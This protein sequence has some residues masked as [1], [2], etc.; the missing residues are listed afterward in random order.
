MLGERKEQ[1][2]G[3]MVQRTG[4]LLG[5]GASAGER[6]AGGNGMVGDGS[7]KNLIKRGFPVVW[8]SPEP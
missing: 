6:K 3:I 1:Y 7:G 2:Y 4:I 8:L 5:R